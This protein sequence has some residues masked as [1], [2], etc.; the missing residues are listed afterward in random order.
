[1]RIL[2]ASSVAIVVILTPAA[3]SAFAQAPHVQ[4]SQNRSCRETGTDGRAL[5]GNRTSTQCEYARVRGS[6]DRCFDRTY[7]I[8][9]TPPPDPAP[10]PRRVTEH[11]KPSW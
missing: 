1:M 6:P 10:A 8:A 11:A 7:M 9:A 4:T 5:C 2:L 3:P